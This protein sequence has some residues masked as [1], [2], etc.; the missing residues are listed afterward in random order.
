MTPAS[1]RSIQAQP[2]RFLI[3][4]IGANLLGGFIVGLL[5]NNGLQFMATLILTGAIV[6]SLQWVVLRKTGSGFRWWPVASAIGWI[7]GTLVVSG[8]Y[9]LFPPI[10]DG[11]RNQF[12]LWEVF[13]LNLVTTPI[14]VL[15]MALAQSLI[16]SGKSRSAGVAVGSWLL[17]S[18]I[19]GA[20]LGAVSAALCAAFC[21]ALPSVLVG[22]VD[23]LGWAVYGL[24][25]GLSWL[26]LSGRDPEMSEE[27]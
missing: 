26:W 27:L 20:M 1:S 17:A 14:S 3:V 21:Q 13:W 9:A 4:W 25:T 19:G 8:S 18:I 23:S 15:A 10:S 6:G 16:L 24:V 7:V 2:L 12:G 22:L 5:E 11:L